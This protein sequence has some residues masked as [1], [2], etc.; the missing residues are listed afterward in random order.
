MAKV[1]HKEPIVEIWERML[2]QHADYTLDLGLNFAHLV[3]I[4]LREPAESNQTNSPPPRPGYEWLTWRSR[5]VLMRRDPDSGKEFTITIEE[6][7]VSGQYSQ[8]S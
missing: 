1:E 3:G 7:D 6:L 8:S 5:R 4:D 2:R